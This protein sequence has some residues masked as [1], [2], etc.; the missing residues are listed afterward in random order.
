VNAGKFCFPEEP[1]VIPFHIAVLGPEK[2]KTA[3]ISGAL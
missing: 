2:V 3:L 1:K